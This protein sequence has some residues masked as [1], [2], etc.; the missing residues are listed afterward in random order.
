MSVNQIAIIA[1]R[2][3]LGL[4]VDLTGGFIPAWALLCLLTINA[5]AVTAKAEL[6]SCHELLT[7]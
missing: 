3:V 4:L 7:K 1:V 6:R 5:L 2:P